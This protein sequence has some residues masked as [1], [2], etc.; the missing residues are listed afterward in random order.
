MKS[1]GNLRCHVMYRHSDIRPYPCKVCNKAFKRAPD[2]DH[3]MKL[4]MGSMDWS[5]DKCGKAFSVKK[6]LKTHMKMHL[7]EA[8]K[9]HECNICG[10]RYY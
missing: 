2:L 10:N 3:H 6:A 4:H 8:E 7:A 9:P 1:Y 5:C